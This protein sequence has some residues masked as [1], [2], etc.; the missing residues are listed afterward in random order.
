MG[1][2]EEQEKARREGVRREEN[3]PFLLSPQG[4]ARGSVILVHGF[5]ASPWEMKLF[6][7]TLVE[8]GYVALGVR[9]PGHGTRAE[10]LA[11][12]RY[13]E[14]LEAV[15]QGY[16][17]LSRQGVPCYGIGMSTGALLLLA[18]ATSRPLAGMVLLSPFLRLRHRLAPAIALLRLFKRFQ[19]HPVKPELAGY[20]YDR[21]PLNGVYQISR[22][23]RL[24]R[25]RLS[26]V[27]VPTLLI[28]TAGDQ[29]VDAES[30]RE[31]FRR[32]ASRRKEYHCFGPDVPHVLATRENPRW[33]ETLDLTLAFLR[34]LEQAE[35][36]QRRDDGKDFGP[37]GP[38]PPG[39]RSC[40]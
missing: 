22:L 13:E 7:E 37:A 26:Q 29:T 14:W 1:I 40:R 32:I 18:L 24:V 19:P 38:S 5:T 10:D 2:A 31:L 17:L 6:G 4:P 35:G 20:Y 3:L 36:G 39:S 9:L 33:S 15:S 30:A 21:R 12:R 27:T 11:K 16:E 28:G 23:I 34:S 8:E 25:S